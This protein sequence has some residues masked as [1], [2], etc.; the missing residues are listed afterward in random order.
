MQICF[1]QTSEDVLLVFPVEQK[2]M[3]FKIHRGTRGIQ[4][5]DVTSG[6]GG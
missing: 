2:S 3:Q 1:H 5:T 6:E 4:V